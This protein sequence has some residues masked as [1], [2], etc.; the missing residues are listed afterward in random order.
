[1]DDDDWVD[2]Y[3]NSKIDKKNNTTNELSRYFT[4]LITSP[5]ITNGDNFFFENKE[6][7]FDEIEEEDPVSDIIPTINMLYIIFN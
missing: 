6:E 2:S 5:I 1:M 3:E 7:N 4:F